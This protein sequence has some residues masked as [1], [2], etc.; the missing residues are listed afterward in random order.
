MNLYQKVKKLCADRNISVMHMEEQLNFPRGSVYK[1][2]A[3]IPSV[4]KV[5]QVADFL[6]VTVDELINGE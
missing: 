2:D 4:E 6:K 3:N 5:K 1:W